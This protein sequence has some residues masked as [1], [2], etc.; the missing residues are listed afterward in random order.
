MQSNKVAYK[1]CRLDLNKSQLVL[2][3]MGSTPF[4]SPRGVGCG[5]FVTPFGKVQSNKVAY[6]WCRLNLCKAIK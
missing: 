4:I 2:C 1:W 5:S 6:K 3:Y